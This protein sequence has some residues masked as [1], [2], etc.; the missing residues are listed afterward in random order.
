MPEDRFLIAWGGMSFDFR[1]FEAGPDPR[2]QKWEVELLWL[3]TG[4]S[5]RH[6]D[7]V[8][9]K[10]LLASGA[11]C[12][13]KVIAL[14]HPDLLAPSARTGRAVTDPW[15]ARL[16]ARHLR[17]MVETDQDMDKSLVTCTREELERY[18]GEL[19]SGAPS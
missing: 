12:V 15:C 1:V 16:A 5:I 4:I 9:V 19:Q 14:S 3:Q 10:F 7:T 18:A 6:S 2:G 17:H 8:D 13:E 11:E